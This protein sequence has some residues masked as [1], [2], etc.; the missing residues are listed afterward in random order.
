MSTYLAALCELGGTGISRRLC[1]GSVTRVLL[2]A[3]LQEDA[4]CSPGRLDYRGF[5]FFCQ[6][7]PHEPDMSTVELPAKHGDSE[8]PVAL[9]MLGTA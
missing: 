4:G 5:A 2:G 9:T 6:K 8:K 7:S 3:A 1:P